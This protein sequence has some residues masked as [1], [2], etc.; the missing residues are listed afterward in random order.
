MKKILLLFTTI[1]F[2]FVSA[3]KSEAF[4]FKKRYIFID[5][6]A[7]KGESIEAFMKTQAYPLRKWEIYSFEANPELIPIILN[8]YKNVTVLNKAIWV[9]DGSVD[10]YIAAESTLSSS[11]IKDKKTG[12][13]S[14]TPISVPSVNFSNWVKKKFRNKDYVVVKFD[15]EG[16]E[17]DVLDKMLKD[18]SISLIDVL[19]IE[20]H[21]ER[22]HIN[23]A[24]DKELVEKIT[25]KET[26]VIN[27]GFTPLPIGK[28]FNDCLS[29]SNKEK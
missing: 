21:N 6:G 1:L 9:N 14:K 26:R 25:N 13:L 29:T 5:G 4:F 20:F 7:H 3:I 15:I 2:L 23:P 28:R 12:M 18:G 10:F 27:E 17:Y 22:V 11:I 16:A 19:Y 24:K 8:K